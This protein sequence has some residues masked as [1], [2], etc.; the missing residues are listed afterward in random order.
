MLCLDV[1]AKVEAL[2]GVVARA[3]AQLP[4]WREAFAATKPARDREL[5]QLLLGAHQAVTYV[6]CGPF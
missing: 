3:R 1:A 4:A 5:R 2:T 6:P